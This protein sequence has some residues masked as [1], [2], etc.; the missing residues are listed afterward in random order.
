MSEIIRIL[1]NSIANKISAGDV[2]QRPSSVVKELLENSIDAEAKSIH[3]ILQDAGKSI[4]KVI[5]DGKGMS[6]SDARM[7]FLR[8]STSKIESADDLFRIRTMG[9]RG[10]ALYSIASV[11]QVEMQTRRKEDEIGISLFIEENKIKGEEFVKISKGTSITIKNIFYNLPE[12][13]KFLKSNKLELRNIMDE[14]NRLA[15]AHPNI[16]FI[17]Y[18]KRNNKIKKYFDFLP[19]SLRTR[20]EDLLEIKINDSMIPIEKKVHGVHL[21]GYIVNPS[22]SNKSLKEQFL[23]V[24]RRYIKSSY[25]DKSVLKAYKGFGNLHPSYFLFFFLDPR[26]IDVNFHPSKNE[27]KFENEASIYEI[28]YYSILR[29]VIPYAIKTSSPSHNLI[30]DANYS[31]LFN[32][33]EG[34]STKKLYEKIQQDSHN[35]DFRFRRN[36]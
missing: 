25:L 26:F 31:P 23:F 24:N 3:L 28:L 5:D 14:F 36:I 29:G 6:I 2:V 7:S 15:M 22:Y 35:I 30:A 19:V 20:I 32:L 13:R 21:K 11:C 33:N 18:H 34:G 10:L 16:R 17:L 4:I 12:R 8:Y 27:I 1:P 9:F